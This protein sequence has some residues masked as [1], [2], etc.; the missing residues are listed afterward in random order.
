MLKRAL[1]VAAVASALGVA[2]EASAYCRSTTC[3]GDCARDEFG[4]KIEGAKLFWASGCVGFSLQKDASI[5]IP[6]KYFRQVAEK[7][8]VT[9]SQIDCGTGLSS[10]AFSETEDVG[11]HQTEYNSAGTNANIIMFQDAK[12]VYIGADNTLAKTTVTYDVD[13]G[14]IFDADIEINHANNNFTIND[15]AVDYDLQSVL[16]HEIG[17]FMGFDHSDEA[18]ATMNAG[19]EEG[20]IDLRTLDPD[21]EAVACEVYPPERPVVC[22][23]NPRGGLG[24]FCGGS[25]DPP[26]T[27]DGGTDSGGCQLSGAPASGASVLGPAIAVAAFF[28]RRRRSR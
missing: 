7:S 12:W 5:H 16:T 11:C 18:L 28:L 22:D 27:D 19:Y 25:H 13:T 14:E 10:L 20:T 2:T 26:P 21:D 9:W 8:F 24:Y 15:D 23:L 6:M 17:H 4:C 1:S 3:T